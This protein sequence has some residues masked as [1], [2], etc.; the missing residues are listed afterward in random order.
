MQRAVTDEAGGGK[1][2]EKGLLVLGSSQ[3]SVEVLSCQSCS[4]FSKN[5]LTSSSLLS[6]TCV[7]PHQCKSL[8]FS[9]NE[10]KIYYHSW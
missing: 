3:C 4:V 7:Q 8:F 1:E 5:L 10:P 6:L 9:V 2:V